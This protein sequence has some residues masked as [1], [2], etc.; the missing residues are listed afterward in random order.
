MGQGAYCATG[1]ADS[2]HAKSD[3]RP[4]PADSLKGVTPNAELRDHFAPITLT[5]YSAMTLAASIK[6]GINSVAEMIAYAKANPGKLNYSSPGTGTTQH[7][8]IKALKNVMSVDLVHVPYRGSAGALTEVSVAFVP[9][10]LA[11]P[12]Y[13]AG[14]L[15]A[16]AVGSPARHPMLPD[17]PT[18]QESG[19]P[20]V[21]SNP[22]HAIAAP[23]ET[24]RPIIDK[25]NA[26]VR[27][28]LKI[29]DVREKLEGFGL[30]I[31][32][33]SPEEM[34]ALME[35][36]SANSAELI[37]KNRISVD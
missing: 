33:G 31:E 9:I 3:S 10:D 6:S 14:A 19:V 20:G 13:K 36:D 4:A 18:L 27:A 8:S 23:K 1:S 5:S 16:L 28:I 11:T 37:R 26:E 24:P 15:K 12:H 25:L 34:Q 2:R 21:E 30:K 22:W 17:V 32:T 35:R 7:L 29:P